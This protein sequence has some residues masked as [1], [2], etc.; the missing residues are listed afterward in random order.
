MFDTLVH[1]KT[2]LHVTLCSEDSTRLMCL[3]VFPLPLSLPLPFLSSYSDFLS[4]VPFSFLPL[5]LTFALR[6]TPY[7]HCYR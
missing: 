3:V 4:L 7:P 5:A 6:L 2:F 1:P